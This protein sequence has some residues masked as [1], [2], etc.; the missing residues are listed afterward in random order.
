MKRRRVMATRMFK[1]HGMHIVCVMVLMIF[2]FQVPTLSYGEE[3]IT[4]APYRIV[5][6][7]QG[8]WDDIQAVIRMPLA[9]GYSL[10]G[11]EVGLYFDDALVCYAKSFRYCY[12]DDNFLAGFDRETVQEYAEVNGLGNTIVTATVSGW[13]SADLYSDGELIDSYT[14]EFIGYDDVELKD[15]GRK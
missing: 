8:N 5:L 2:A 6:N 7:A 10:S 13:F 15:P 4:I 12:L 1:K 11:F 9:S 14:R 3:S